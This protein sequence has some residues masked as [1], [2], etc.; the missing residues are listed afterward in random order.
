MKKLRVGGGAKRETNEIWLEHRGGAS[1]QWA[2]PSGDAAGSL[3][4]LERACR[5]V[6][7]TRAVQRGGRGGR[8]KTSTELTAGGATPRARGAGPRCARQSH[9]GHELGVAVRVVSRW[10]PRSAGRRKTD[11]ERLAAGARASGGLPAWTPRRARSGEGFPGVGRGEPAED[12]TPRGVGPGCRCICTRR[13][14]H[15]NLCGMASPGVSG[16][17]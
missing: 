2:L 7:I 6:L 4:A 13:Q 17:R 12:P 11:R 9:R 10:R 1:A 5:A 14:C 15:A 16:A 8:G 3:L